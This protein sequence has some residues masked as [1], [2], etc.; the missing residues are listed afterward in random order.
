MAESD[1]SPI[2]KID[3]GLEPPQQHLL[4]Y[5]ERF[6]KYFISINILL[7]LFLN[8]YLVL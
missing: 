8:Q 7:N 6:F 2:S 1:W 5:D 3:P 4:K